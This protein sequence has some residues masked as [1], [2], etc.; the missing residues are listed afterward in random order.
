VIT[1]DSSGNRGGDSSPEK[2]PDMT[3]KKWVSLNWNSEKFS[4]YLIKEGL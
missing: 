3:K 4:S 2:P 1:D